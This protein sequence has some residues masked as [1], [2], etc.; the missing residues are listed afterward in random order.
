[1]LLYFAYGSNLST[2]RLRA[3]VPSAR[4]L[5]TATL[6]LYRLEF[7]KVG[8][9]GSAKCDALHT[10]DERDAVQGVVFELPAHE[11][12]A[13]DRAEG[14]GSGYEIRRVT[15]T[16]QDG[17]VLEAFTYCAT[18]TDPALQPYD[19]YLEHV[20][21]GALE[22]GLPADYVAALGKVA[23]Y[24]DF[25]PLRRARELAIYRERS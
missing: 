6:T 21:K 7:H 25:D 16:L 18:V 14:L 4:K 11:Q 20:L 5:G 2:P 9:D 15:V 12:P 22:H 8:R 10:G 24:P 3:R 17:R 13:L 1:M 19:W 23:A